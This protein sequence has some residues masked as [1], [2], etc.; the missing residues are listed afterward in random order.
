MDLDSSEFNNTPGGG[1]G[2][3]REDYIQKTSSFLSDI[4]PEE[5]ASKYGSNFKV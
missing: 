1:G 4:F 2:D 3:I 5:T